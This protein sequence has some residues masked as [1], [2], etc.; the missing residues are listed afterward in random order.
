[1]DKE[2]LYQKS[3]EMIKKVTKNS[4]KVALVNVI[5]MDFNTMEMSKTVGGGTYEFGKVLL[6]KKD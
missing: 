6:N 5:S 2:K 1:M 3:I 4:S